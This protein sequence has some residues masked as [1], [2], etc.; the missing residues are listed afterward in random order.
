MI[1]VPTQQPEVHHQYDDQGGPQDGQVVVEGD[2]QEGER[3]QQ[4]LGPDAD[5]RSVENIPNPKQLVW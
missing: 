4:C 1:P 3:G 2:G 5:D